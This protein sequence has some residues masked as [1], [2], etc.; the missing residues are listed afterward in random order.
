MKYAN[1]DAWK[2]ATPWDDEPEMPEIFKT[3]KYEYFTEDEKSIEKFDETMLKYE[4]HVIQKEYADR[5]EYLEECAE[6][7]ADNLDLSISEEFCLKKISDKQYN[8]YI[9]AVENGYKGSY[10]GLSY[11]HHYAKSWNKRRK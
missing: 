5:N 9:D 7:V 2:L 6:N 10:K 1:Y 11:R 8:E 4:Y 3:D